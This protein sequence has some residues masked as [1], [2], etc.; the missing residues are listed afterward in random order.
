MTSQ[1]KLPPMSN[2][3]RAQYGVARAQQM[4]F[5]A[6]C[7]LWRRRRAEGVKQRDIADFTGQSRSTVS[8]NLSGPANWTFRTFGQYVEA[9][10]GEL[11]IIVH[12]MEDPLDQPRKMAHFSTQKGN[13]ILPAPVA[14]RTTWH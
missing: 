2:L 1:S 8:R 13:K 11:E 7:T 12:A 6:V 9:L 5:D 4:A 10:D 14:S 3:E